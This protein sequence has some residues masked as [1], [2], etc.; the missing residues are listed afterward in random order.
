VSGALALDQKLEKLREVL[1]AMGRVLIAYSGGVDSTLLVRIAAEEL[2]DGVLAVTA[3][4]PIYDPAETR[5]ACELAASFGVRHMTV[6]IDVLEDER[7]C[8]NPPDR[9]YHCKKKLLR[10]LRKIARGEGIAWVAD[11]GHVGDL[12]DYRPGRRAVQE[13][14]VRSPLEEA[15]LGKAEIRELSRRMGLPTWDLPPMACLASRFPYGERITAEKLERVQKAEAALREMGFRLVR[16]RSHGNMARIEVAPSNGHGLAELARPG[17]RENVV[18]ELKALGF[19][20]VAL[21]LEGY[22]TGSMNE[23]L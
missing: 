8:S 1:R 23:E 13:E 22:R 6:A 10:K 18:R 7:F 21:D 19:R 20:Y 9:C 5:R 16:V 2:G 4:S 17:V 14:D 15:G 3:V 12:T 11:A